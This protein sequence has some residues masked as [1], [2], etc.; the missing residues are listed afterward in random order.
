MGFGE[1]LRDL[2]HWTPFLGR[3][4]LWNIL[5]SIVAMS[6]GTALGCGFAFMRASSSGSNGAMRTRVMSSARIKM[7]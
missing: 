7:A 4:F 2:L 1:V 3:G 5:I 6:F